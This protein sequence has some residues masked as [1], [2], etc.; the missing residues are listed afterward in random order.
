MMAVS[1]LLE[2]ME[3][4]ASFPPTN[5][6]QAVVTGRRYQFAIQCYNNAIGA[7]VTRM[8]QSDS[9]GDIALVTCVLFICVEFLQGDEAEA[10]ALCLQ[11]SKVLQ[12]VPN[13]S[14]GLNT[15]HISRRQM[16]SSVIMEDV[17]PIFIRLGILSTL[18]GQPIETGLPLNVLREPPPPECS[19]A[20][21]SLSEAGDELYNLMD[22]C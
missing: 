19:F 1:S 3:H 17:S 13:T 12:S 14:C 20:F 10:L 4:E 18:F 16:T 11:G 7:L 9:A 15:A 22:I 21:Q 6:D 5:H 2:H 8:K